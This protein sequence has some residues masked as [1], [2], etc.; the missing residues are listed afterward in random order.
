MPVIVVNKPFALR[1]NSQAER[2]DFGVGRHTVSEKELAHWFMQACL[3][4]EDGRAEMVSGVEEDGCADGALA[5]PTR[6]QLNALNREK[7][8]DLAAACGLEVPEGTNKA[9]IVDLLLAGC[10]GVTLV[11]GPDGIYVQKAE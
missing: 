3:A 9:A 7:L 4:P 6:S 11:K 2:R 1:I 5:A 8:D 10:E